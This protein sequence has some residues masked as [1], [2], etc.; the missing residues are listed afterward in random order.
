M[1]QRVE[2]ASLS[3]GSTA[4]APL[5]LVVHP[6]CTPHAAPI[7]FPRC[8]YGFSDSLGRVALELG[9]H[10]KCVVRQKGVTEN[11]K[12]R[13]KKYFSPEKI[14]FR[15]HAFSSTALQ[16]LSATLSRPPTAV[17]IVRPLRFSRQ[18]HTSSSRATLSTLFFV[19][20][21]PFFCSPPFGCHLPM[22]AFERG[23]VL[24]V[25]ARWRVPGCVF[26]VS[27][28]SPRTRILAFF[29]FVFP[30]LKSRVSSRYLLP[31]ACGG[32]GCALVWWARGL[33]RGSGRAAFV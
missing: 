25:G 16:V 26:V 2:T 3:T 1:V 6:Q 12:K 8:R 14:I 31:S 22:R 5:E 18:V 33:A 10:S 13:L 11:A 17:H 20:F 24:V 9:P 27:R 23:H 19:L 29:F 28:C 30:T 32:C 7:L 15:F 4:F 21:F